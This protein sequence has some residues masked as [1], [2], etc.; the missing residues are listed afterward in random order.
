M[1]NH[2]TAAAIAPMD[3]LRPKNV[4]FGTST[5]LNRLGRPF[6]AV[7]RDPG[8]QNLTASGPSISHSLCCH[9]IRMFRV[10]C[11]LLSQ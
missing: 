6:S 1:P 11:P 3:A 7:G 9:A 5:G 2:S 4:C 10:I 8:W